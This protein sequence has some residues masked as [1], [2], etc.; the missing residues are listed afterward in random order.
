MLEL[1]DHL[2]VDF[3]NKTKTNAA[4]ETVQLTGN[5]EVIGEH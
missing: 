3:C 4:P 2:L 1:Q 5:S